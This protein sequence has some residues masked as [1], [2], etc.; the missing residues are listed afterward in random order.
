[1]CFTS[2]MFSCKKD[3]VENPIPNQFSDGLLV[4]NEG[5]FHQNNST[6]DWIDLKTEEVSSNIF[7][8]INQRL[9]GDTGNDL[10][11]YGGKI[12]IAAT[13]SSTVEILNR[14]DLK[15]IK[16]ISFNYNNQ[17]QE[18][19]YFAKHKNKVFVTSFDGYV[20]AID[21]T[22]LNVT[23]RIKVGRNPDGICISGNS[24]FV[25]NSGGLDFGNMDSTVMQIDLNTLEVVDT[26][27]VG[28][29][30]GRMI[31]DD[32]GNAYV[33][34]QGDYINNPSELVKINTQT[35]E[36]VN[37]Q[38]PA[39]SIAKDGDKLYIS[40]YDFNTGNSIV[41][42][43]NSASQSLENPNF[44]NSNSIETL[45]GIFPFEG[46]IICLD[47]MN[48]TNSGYLRFFD[49]NGTLKKSI[50]VGL[51]PTAILKL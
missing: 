13:T 21:T 1:M 35:K 34:K 25:A 49:S 43:Y 15:S 26:F 42:I 18:P 28:E 29:N 37:L 17:A 30:P 12:Y 48:Y 5:L 33:V 27:V 11:L 45:Y 8:S 23:K 39:T 50:H 36:I 47:A 31:A 9:L 40:H 14:N 20:S 38:I 2:L 4:L 46:G 19:R 51:N 44:I 16:Q 6:L 41:S 10:L 3:V 24:I 32:Y 22:T 7:E